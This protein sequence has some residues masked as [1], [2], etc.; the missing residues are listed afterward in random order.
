MPTSEFNE[1]YG[2]PQESPIDEL[3]ISLEIPHWNTTGKIE[4]PKCC[5]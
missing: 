1:K 3:N 5:S 2:G 4:L